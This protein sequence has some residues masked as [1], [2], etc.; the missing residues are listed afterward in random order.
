MFNGVC[1]QTPRR[2][3]H[4]FSSFLQQ[5]VVI[6][7]CTFMV[8]GAFH[9]KSHLLSSRSQSSLV[10][11][12]DHL[13]TRL[14]TTLHIPR[15][16]TLPTFPPLVTETTT[17]TIHEPH[18]GICHFGLLANTT[19][20]TEPLTFAGAVEKLHE[21][22]DVE[23]KISAWSCTANLQPKTSSSCK[24]SPRL[25]STIIKSNRKNWRQCENCQKFA[26]ECS[27]N[28]IGRPTFCGL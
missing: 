10:E 17:N 2:T 15:D 25:A 14:G 24:K 26:L 18:E 7:T 22:G 20:F 9:P 28:S 13:Q 23:S 21:F 6:N 27:L 16:S 8:H 4:A 19:P 3:P 5:R 1:K 11:L 12:M